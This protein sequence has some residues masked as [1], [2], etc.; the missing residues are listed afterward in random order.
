MAFADTFQSV[1][2]SLPD[3][4]TDLEIDLRITDETRYVDA[5]VYLATVNAQPY[6]KYDWHWRILVAHRFGHAAAAPAVHGA[7]KLLDD[8]GFEGELVVREVRSGRVEVVQMWGRPES[9]RQEFKRL[10]AQ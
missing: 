10:R 3:D 7:L 8:A 2:D 9:V 1:V 5:A 4:W 6:S